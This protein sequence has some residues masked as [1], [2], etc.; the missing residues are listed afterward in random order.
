MGDTIRS[1]Y[2][3]LEGMTS[4]GLTVESQEINISQIQQSN[5]GNMQRQYGGANG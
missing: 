1:M 5:M 4:A 3:S 2:M